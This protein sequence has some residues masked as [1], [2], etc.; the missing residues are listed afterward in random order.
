M[1]TTAIINA[2][3]VPVTAKPFDGTI[4]LSDG[5]ILALGPD[6]KAPADAEIVD[7]HGAWALP[8]LV[9]AHAH[10]GIHEESN[11]WAGND[12]NEGIDANS[13]AL[14]AIDA[15]HPTDEGFRDALSGGITTLVV[16]P[17]SASP[18][19]GQ[20]VAIKTWGRYIDEMVLKQPASMK[21]ALGENPKRFYGQDQK[22]EPRT[23]MGV[24]KVIRQAF[25]A[26]QDYQAAQEQ[27]RSDGKPFTRNLTHEAMLQVLSGEIPWCQHVHRV[28]DIATALRLRDEF[29][30][31]LVINHGTEAHL[32]A[33]VLAERQ[34]PVIIG[35]LFTS[36][37]KQELAH[38][39]LRNPGILA[40]A[41]VEIAITTDAPVVPISFLI[42]QAA[43]AM[44]EGLD[45]DAALRSV[46][47]NPA[48][49]LGL[50]D[51]VGSLEAGKDADV[52][53]WDDDP[54]DWRSRATQ[55]FVNGRPI[56]HFDAERGIGRTVNPYPVED[57]YPA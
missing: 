44:K 35:P 5:R 22:K 9:E 6:V 47:I 39:S 19:G 43:L 41:G 40:A 51:R 34:I 30:Y 50:D 26:A 36:R 37:S 18:I 53:L 17:G 23:R 55:V 49:M 48:R 1:T 10:V 8:G 33:D 52:V 4:V 42:Y 57:N 28:D 54:L 20:T 56:Y 29:G 38:R 25:V 46:T 21:S 7:A 12:T 24:A 16:K 45:P 27:A 14:R 11:G 31:R 15:I 13:A 2:H 32:L 3:V